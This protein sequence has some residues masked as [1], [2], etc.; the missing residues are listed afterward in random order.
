[1]KWMIYPVA[2]DDPR[3]IKQLAANLFIGSCGKHPLCQKIESRLSAATGE[4]FVIA[5]E[6]MDWDRIAD[7]RWAATYSGGKQLGEAVATPL[8]P[9]G[10]REIDGLILLIRSWLAVEE[11]RIVVFENFWSEKADWIGTKCLDTRDRY[12]G[13][14]VYHILTSEDRDPERTEDAIRAP[15]SQWFVGVCAVSLSLSQG[16]ELSEQFLDEAAQN[17]QCIFVP[18]F[19]DEGFLVW[20]TGALRLLTSGGAF[21]GRVIAQT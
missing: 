16:D 19:D 20:H 2:A 12:Y 18:A 14:T 6:S 21:A 11:R 4:M 1:M 7:F 5:M 10:D 9:A 13:E 15:W 17:A 3:A 8:I